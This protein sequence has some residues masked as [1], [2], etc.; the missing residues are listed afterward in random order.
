MLIYA[1]V[2]VRFVIVDRVRKEREAASW[3]LLQRGYATGG[4]GSQEQ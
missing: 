1:F 2:F 4:T 3:F